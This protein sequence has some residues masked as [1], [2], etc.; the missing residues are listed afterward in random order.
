MTLRFPVRLLTTVMSLLIG[1][2]LLLGAANEAEAQAQAVFGNGGE[3]LGFDGVQVGGV[4]YDVRIEDG[5]VADVFGNPP[6][7]VFA[8]NSDAQAAAQQLTFELNNLSLSDPSTVEGC[9][10][11]ADCVP[12]TPYLLS[13]GSVFV[14]ESLLQ[15]PGE[16]PFGSAIASVPETLDTATSA[17]LAWTRWIPENP[18]GGGPCTIGSNARTPIL[19]GT[20]ELFGFDDITIAG[21]T[22][23]VRFEEGTFADVYVDASGI[24]FAGSGAAND[25]ILELAG[26]LS[27]VSDVLDEPEILTGCESPDSCTMMVPYAISGGF[28]DVREASVTAPG[29]PLPGAIASLPLSFD[30]TSSDGLVWARW[31]SPCEEPASNPTPGVYDGS[32]ELLG[33]DG[34]SVGGS[35]YNVRFEDGTLADV[36]EEPAVLTF[37]SNAGAMTAANFLSVFVARKGIQTPE[38]LSGCESTTDC[39][40]LTPYLSTS[41]DTFVRETT[42][43]APGQLPPGAIFSFPSSLD[44]TGSDALVWTRWIPTSGGSGTPTCTGG[45]GSSTPL[46]DSFGE[47]QGFDEIT[48]AGSDWNVRFANGTFDTATG[49]VSELAFTGAGT[50][51]DASMAL[52]AALL[53]LPA[54]AM[55]PEL[56]AGCESVDSCTFAT[57]FGVSGSSVD[58][59][60]TSIVAPGIPPT[61][62]LVELPLT[63]DT[64]ST[65]GL[66]WSDWSSACAVPEPSARLVWPFLVAGLSFLGR[67]RRSGRE[68]RLGQLWLGRSRRSIRTP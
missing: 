57:P 45:A 46:F 18:T 9:D 29:S 39:L 67:S 20:G 37:S 22:F 62:V 38:L 23:D 32:G 3:L 63:F 13:G 41:T 6:D 43:Q 17:V 26:A 21:H 52:S 24:L 16:P 4:V 33:F 15:A 35:S 66:V 28:T 51:Q 55:D 50:A 47:L 5:T 61:G 42:I 30:T 19:T 68:E 34:L 2:S 1:V 48:I 14:R 12:L 59:R 64:T 25:A 53:A 7:F 31:T 58:L 44:T 8:N 40:P 60:E 56:V 65:D 11:P 54:I 27:T 36:F 49:G 10:D